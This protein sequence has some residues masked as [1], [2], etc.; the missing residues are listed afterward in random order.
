[1]GPTLGGQFKEVIGLGSYNI[2]W[3]RNKAIDIGEWSVSGGGLLER[4]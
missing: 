1:M 4:F 2:V 3:D